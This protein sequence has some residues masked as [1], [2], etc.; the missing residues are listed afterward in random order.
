MTQAIEQLTVNVS[1][2]LKHIFFLYFTEI[3]EIPVLV[4][5]FVHRCFNNEARRSFIWGFCVVLYRFYVE[6]IQYKTKPNKRDL[7]AWSVSTLFAY[8]YSTGP[9]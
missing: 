4:K 6:P 5:H 1:T 2:F 9:Y 3:T 8:M 7:R